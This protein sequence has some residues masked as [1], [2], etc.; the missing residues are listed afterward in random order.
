MMCYLFLQLPRS[1]QRNFVVFEIRDLW[2]GF[3]FSSDDLTRSQR[4][5]IAA[6]QALPGCPSANVDDNVMLD[7]VIAYAAWEY[8]I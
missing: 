4:Y 6:F 3:H 2:R 8:V 1:F 7:D 5:E